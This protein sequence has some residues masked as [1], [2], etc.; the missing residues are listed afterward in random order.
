MSKAVLDTDIFSEV[1]RPECHSD[2][3]CPNVPP[4][5]WTTH[6][7][8]HHSV[9]EMVKGFQK[10]QRPQKILSL[11]TH[12]N[13]EEILEFDQAAAELAGRIWGDPERTGQP[14]GLAD[15]MIAA[16]ALRHRLL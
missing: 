14:L 7:L 10:V 15:P 12:V 6:P 11:L 3:P 2:R 13:S 1:L 9:M 5:A 8:R 4:G 16:V